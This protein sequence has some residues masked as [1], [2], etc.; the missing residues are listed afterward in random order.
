MKGFKDY[1]NKYTR[2]IWFA[3]TIM[4]VM[5]TIL[6]FL[7]QNVGKYFPGLPQDFQNYSPGDMLKTSRGEWRPYLF[8]ADLIIT[9]N[10]IMIGM[11][12]WELNTT[13]S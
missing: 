4:S 9:A 5:V 2:S 7:P 13:L 1:T 6:T 11:W 3:L 8:L 10:A 12:M